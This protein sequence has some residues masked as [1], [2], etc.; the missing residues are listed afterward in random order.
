MKVSEESVASG[1]YVDVTDSGLV[2]FLSFKF[3]QTDY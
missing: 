2:P 1:H 3:L